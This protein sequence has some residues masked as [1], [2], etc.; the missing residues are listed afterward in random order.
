MI[1][2]A[3]RSTR[4]FYR[5]DAVGWEL[6]ATPQFLAEGIGVFLA[7]QL[8]GPQ[9]RIEQ[10]EQDGRIPVRQLVGPPL[11]LKDLLGRRLRG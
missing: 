6:A 2:S 3:S 7:G 9:A 10:H 1:L 4:H 5:I 8:K 11:E